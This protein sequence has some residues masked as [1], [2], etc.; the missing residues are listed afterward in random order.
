MF[1]DQPLAICHGLLD[2]AMACRGQGDYGCLL[3]DEQAGQDEK[4]TRP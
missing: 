3:H 1:I 2:R 4:L